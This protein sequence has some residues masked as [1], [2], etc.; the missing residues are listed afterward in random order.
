ME[1]SIEEILPKPKK[2]INKNEKLTNIDFIN[3]MGDVYNWLKMT[4][5]KF[6]L[7]FIMFLF[8]NNPMLFI[9]FFIV[10]LKN[11]HRLE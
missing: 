8:A 11:K 4:L 3:D 6:Y 2:K 10:L 5:V 1:K 9:T 7:W